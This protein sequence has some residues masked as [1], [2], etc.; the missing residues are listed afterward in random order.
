[1]GLSIDGAWGSLGGM[2]LGSLGSYGSLVVVVSLVIAV[3]MIESVDLFDHM[4]FKFDAF[5]Q[6]IGSLIACKIG[7]RSICIRGCRICSAPFFLLHRF[8]G[9]VV[10][11]IFVCVDVAALAVESGHRCGYQS[12][13]NAN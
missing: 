6:G 11:S 2:H 12:R 3:L 9:A 7:G 10:V 1:M 13:A 4:R 8:I 5:C